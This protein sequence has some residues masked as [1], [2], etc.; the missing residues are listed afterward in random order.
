MSTTEA[1]AKIE[2]RI[3]HRAPFLFLD[4][5]VEEGQDWALFRWRVPEDAEWFRGHYPGQ[6][7]TPGVILVEHGLQAGAALVA[8][9][10][11]EAGDAIEGVPVL[12]RI[13]D[14]RF[15][16]MVAPGET[17]ECRVQLIERIGP[18]WRLAAR[19]TVEGKRCVQLAAIVTTAQGEQA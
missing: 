15:R 6:P 14:A 10:I 18:A 5:L 9:L 16:R 13:E 12:T 3:P 4:E 2:E 19:I 8:R 17:L 11:A 1:R 7:V